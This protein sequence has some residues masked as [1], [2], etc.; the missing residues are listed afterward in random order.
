MSTRG[1]GG[2]AKAPR[3]NMRRGFLAFPG[4]SV[5]E[6]FRKCE[7]AGAD[8]TTTVHKETIVRWFIDIDGQ[9]MLHNTDGPAHQQ[10]GQDT[11]GGSMQLTMEIWYL[12]DQ[13]H[14]VDE[15]PDRPGH[16]LPANINYD[17][18][19]K[20][21]FKEGVYMNDSTHTEPFWDP[22]FYPDEVRHME[23]RRKL[24]NERKAIH[25]AS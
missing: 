20:A 16:Y 18:R 12:Y 13:P 24:F 4:M 17:Q 11:D 6:Y 3:L 9:K 10:F 19:Y 8:V 21:Y 25:D 22:E 5:K 1:A 2:A 7:E 15:D 14:R 23:D